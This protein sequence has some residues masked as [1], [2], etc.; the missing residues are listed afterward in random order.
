MD[1]LRALQLPFL[2]IQRSVEEMIS[3][4]HKDTDSSDS[5][6]MNSQTGKG[7]WVKHKWGSMKVKRIASN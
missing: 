4:S 2:E 1:S 6:E 7:I 5:D 3:Y